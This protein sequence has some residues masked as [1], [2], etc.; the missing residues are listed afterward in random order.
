M[1]EYETQD[2]TLANHSLND[3]TSLNSQ[4][5]EGHEIHFVPG[6]D[7]S[8]VLLKPVEFT[9]EAFL[10]GLRISVIVS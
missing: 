7:S 4:G 9:K 10:L 5:G 8:D 6:K 1:V 3:L 2:A